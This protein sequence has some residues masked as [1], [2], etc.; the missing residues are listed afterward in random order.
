MH[1]HFFKC[2]VW[3]QNKDIYEKPWGCFS[4]FTRNIG[5]IIDNNQYH[6]NNILVISYFVFQLS[7]SRANVLKLFYLSFFFIVVKM[8]S[9]NLNI[10][11]YKMPCATCRVKALIM[12]SHNLITH[13]FVRVW[14]W[15]VLLW[16]L[17]IYRHMSIK[18]LRFVIFLFCYA[19]VNKLFS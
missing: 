8:I 1:F 4:Q 16:R 18:S 3:V 17:S 15:K 19:K 5:N 12:Y 10:D 6:W 7:I 13:T 2:H 14:Q 11:F 9:E